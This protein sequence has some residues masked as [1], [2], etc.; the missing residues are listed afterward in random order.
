MYAYKAKK[1]A[2]WS[3]TQHQTDRNQLSSA[4]PHR[5]AGEPSIEE[6]SE[7][8][9]TTMSNTERKRLPGMSWTTLP[10]LGSRPSDYLRIH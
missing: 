4:T 5:P 10:S 1:R 3:T 7:K 8:P 9:A 6:G 2:T